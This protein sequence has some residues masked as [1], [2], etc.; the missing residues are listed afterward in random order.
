[1]PITSSSLEK[2]F[3]SVSK[4]ATTA[5]K[6][7]ILIGGTCV[8]GYSLKIDYFPQDLSV[9][10]GLLFLMAAACFG[11]IYVF[12]TASLVAL[13]ITMSPVTRIVFKF[14][15]WGMN[16]F[17]KRKTEPAHELAPFGWSASLLA[18]FS[19]III[20]IL[21]SRDSAAYWNLPLLSV[22]LYLFYSIYRSS[23][24]KIRKIE[25]VKSSVLHTDEKEN[26]AQLGS[27]DKLQKVQLFSLI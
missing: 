27:L 1:M 24:N 23:G 6:F 11:V 2:N 12:F 8:L 17:H 5:S 20:L 26:V 10:D 16:L 25:R 3:E 13:G 21:G 9:G 14:I 7:G 18:L 15:A 19:V 22:G 4:I